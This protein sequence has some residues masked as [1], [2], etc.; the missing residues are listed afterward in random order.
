MV[1]TA[2]HTQPRNT[3]WDVNVRPPLASFLPE[4]NVCSPLGGCRAAWEQ[5]WAGRWTQDWGVQRGHPAQPGAWLHPACCAVL[6]LCRCQH[7]Y[8]HAEQGGWE[9]RKVF[10]PL[11]FLPL[12]AVPT[13]PACSVLPKRGMVVAEAALS[14]SHCGCGKHGVNANP[15]KCSH[16]RA[17]CSSGVRLRDG[18]C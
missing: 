18:G 12:G 3:A 5:S 6:G 10:I 4:V 11:S 9:G 8:L 2:S 16:C 17:V 15:P 1:T 14:C 7:K 13:R